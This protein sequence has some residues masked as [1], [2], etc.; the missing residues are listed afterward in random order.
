MFGSSSQGR[1]INPRLDYY[2]LGNGQ[3]PAPL[4]QSSYCGGP[5]Y[6][7]L[8]QQNE[9]KR[10]LSSAHSII[11]Y[12]HPYPYQNNNDMRFLLFVRVEAT[13]KK[14]A[15]KKIARPNL[16]KALRC[17][18]SIKMKHTKAAL[19]YIM[20]MQRDMAMANFSEEQQK[21]ND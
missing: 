19:V 12:H 5:C 13:K 1:G 2:L 18:K 21:R 20:T 9:I 11:I 10:I 17:A 14:A 6:K 3:L 7:Q 16:E 15:A 4:K 8:T